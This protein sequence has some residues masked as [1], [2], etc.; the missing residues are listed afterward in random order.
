MLYEIRLGFSSESVQ[1]YTTLE[2]VKECFFSFRWML[3]RLYVRM[4]YTI[5]KVFLNHMY[6]PN[7]ALPIATNCTILPYKRITMV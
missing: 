6:V 7:L 2:D 3:R 1:K 5:R 4:P